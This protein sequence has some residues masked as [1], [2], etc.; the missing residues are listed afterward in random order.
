MI[1]GLRR[2][3]VMHQCLPDPGNGP[4]SSLWRAADA[5]H[6]RAARAPSAPVQP[7]VT[8]TVGDTISTGVEPGAATNGTTAESS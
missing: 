5:V 4:L 2:F 1:A 7:T 3:D 6:D 8:G